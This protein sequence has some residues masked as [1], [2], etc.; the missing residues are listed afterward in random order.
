MWNFEVGESKKVRFLAKNQHT[1][2]LTY[3]L[4]GK[5]KQKLE[6]KGDLEL[7]GQMFFVVHMY[8]IFLKNKKIMQT[9]QRISDHVDNCRQDHYS[10]KL[11]YWTKI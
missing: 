2:G 1:L 10:V 3:L 8:I 9:C 4:K 6:L 5:Q 11:V 7:F